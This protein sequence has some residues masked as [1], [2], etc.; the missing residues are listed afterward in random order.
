MEIVIYSL[1]FLLVSLLI[2]LYKFYKN[3]KYN[4]QLKNTRLKFLIILEIILMSIGSLYA[5]SMI[6]RDSAT[7]NQVDMSRD[8]GTLVLTYELE[9]LPNNKNYD[10]N[11]NIKSNNSNDLIIKPKDEKPIGTSS[12]YYSKEQENPKVI[13]KIDENDNCII[14]VIGRDK[15]KQKVEDNYKFKFKRVKNELSDMM[16][17]EVDIPYNKKGKISKRENN[18][19]IYGSENNNKSTSVYMNICSK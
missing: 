1:V 6:N 10:L 16:G 5:F 11:F 7:F 18:I 4:S 3:K 14:D 12:I 9:G 8:D 19:G 13:F 17:L 15:D 2:S